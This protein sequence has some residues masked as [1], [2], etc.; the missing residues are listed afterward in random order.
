MTDQNIIMNNELNSIIIPDYVNYIGVF[1]TFA[2]NLDCS[3]CINKFNTA[4]ESKMLSGKEIVSGLNR[5]IS[6]PDLPVSLQGG[7]P[8]LH[9]DFY[10]IINNIRQELKIDILTNLT[11]DVKKFVENVKPEKLLRNSPYAPI[12]VSYHPEKSNRSEIIE[13]SLYLQNNGFRVGIYG[14]NLQDYSECN[15]EMKKKCE[16]LNID[17]RFKEFLGFHNGILYG[18]YK[19]PDAIDGKKN[20]KVECKPSELL[21]NPAGDIFKCHYHLYSNSSNSGNLLDSEYRGDFN[22]HICYDYGLCNPC[23]IKIKTNRHQIFGHTSVEIN[24]NLK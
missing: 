24:R 22:S 12:R 20:I 1:L 19:Y 6:R 14:I 21:I 9:P 4:P 5:I 13:K 10:Y 16:I 23:D 15:S 18:Q 2:C 3:Y 17:F 7:E 8:S 11:F